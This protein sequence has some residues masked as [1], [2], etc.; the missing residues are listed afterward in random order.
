MFTT[1]TH[2]IA[3]SLSPTTVP[4]QTSVASGG[5]MSPTP[6]PGRP[7]DQPQPQPQPQQQPLP[8]QQQPLQQQQQTSPPSFP[9]LVKSDGSPSPGAKRPR[10]GSG[11]SHQ[12]KLQLQTQT[13][14]QQVVV[15]VNNVENVSGFFVIVQNTN[16]IH[17]WR[18]FDKT[19]VFPFYGNMDK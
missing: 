6:V 15:P 5:A 18:Q 13:S 3:K 11:G 8:Q 9:G 4:T 10:K 17:S 16:A 2:Q 19:F 7:R 14:S 12:P 1:L